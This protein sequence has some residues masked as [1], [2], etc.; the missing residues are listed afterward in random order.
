MG[1]SEDLSQC[2]DDGD[3]AVAPRQAGLTSIRSISER[4]IST[5]CGRV[6]SSCS[7]C[8]KECLALGLVR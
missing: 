1:E 2:T 8:V 5:T 4:M 7:A 6:T 3:V